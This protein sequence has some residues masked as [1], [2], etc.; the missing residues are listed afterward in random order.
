MITHVERITENSQAKFKTSML[1]SRLCDYSDV[2][3]LVSGTITIDR[4]GNDDN[5]KRLD[6]R[7]EEVIFKNFS[8][9]TDCISEITNT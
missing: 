9:L 8:P 6:E 4:A 2:D 7:N 5:A 1:K 3:I